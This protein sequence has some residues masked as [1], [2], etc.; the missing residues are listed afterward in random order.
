MDLYDREELLNEQQGGKET[1]ERQNKIRVQMGAMGKLHNLVVHIRASSGRTTEFVKCAGRRI[2]LDNRTRWNS[3]YTM[4]KITQE[5]TVKEALV[6]YVE[7]YLD[8]G[9]IDKR[10]ILSPE[11]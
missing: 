3:W 9:T 11:D 7:K 1:K 4:L 2:P 5:Q 10:D 6:S 8:A